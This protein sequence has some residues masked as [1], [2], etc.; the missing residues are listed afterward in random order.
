V[1]KCQ[2]GT[3]LRQPADSKLADHIGGYVRAVTS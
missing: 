1:Q 2:F 3:Q